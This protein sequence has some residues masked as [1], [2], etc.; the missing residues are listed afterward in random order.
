MNK[1][2][3]I[4]TIISGEPGIDTNLISD[5]YHTFGELYEHRIHLWIIL[6]KIYEY[7]WAA[8]NKNPQSSCPVWKSQKHSDG[9]HW[10]GWFI[11]GLTDNNGRQITYHLPESKWGECAFAVELEKCPEFD[12]HTSADVLQRIK[13]LF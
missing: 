5:G 13:E 9:S 3:A 2:I 11:L 7:E 4:N 8:T 10:D 1:E 12:G 6:C